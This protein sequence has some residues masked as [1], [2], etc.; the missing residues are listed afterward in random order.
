MRI[1]LTGPPLQAAEANMSVATFLVANRI[2]EQ[3]RLWD[4]V[5]FA[6]MTDTPWLDAVVSK[7]GAH[8]GQKGVRFGYQSK[9]DQLWKTSP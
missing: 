2:G 9:S 7:G 4:P 5:T 1:F 6:I 8:V 3:L